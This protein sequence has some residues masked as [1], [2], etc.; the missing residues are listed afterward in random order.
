MCSFSVTSRGSARDKLQWAFN[1]YD[2]DGSGYI[3]LDEVTCIVTSMQLN[4]NT[5]EEIAISDDVIADIFKTMDTDE[6]GS[7]SLSEFV[8][9]VNKNP[10]F[11]DM[12]N[13]IVS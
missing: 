1:L 13:G 12:L 5:V 2:V 11:V 7:L 8:E 3:T 6:D 10:I 4:N 9:G